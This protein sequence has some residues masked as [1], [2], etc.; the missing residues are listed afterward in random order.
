MGRAEKS[1]KCAKLGRIAVA[2]CGAGF[3]ALAKYL[4]EGLAAAGNEAADV[5]MLCIAVEYARQQVV[6]GDVARS[7]LPRE[8]GGEIDQTGPCAIRQP[9]L[10]LR[11]FHAARDNID[12]TAEAA[13]HHPV[14]GEPHHLD[15]AEHHVVE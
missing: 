11:D 4:F 15:R 7:G 6:D 9:E 12:D 1:T 13:R 14:D 3:G 10:A 2:F 8:T 5:A